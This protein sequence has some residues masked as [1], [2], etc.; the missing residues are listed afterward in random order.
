MAKKVGITTNYAI[1]YAAK[2]C[3]VDVIAAYPIT[4]QTA[5]VEKLSEFVANGELDA[6]YVPV[7]SEHS[8]LSA[9]IGA[10]VAGARAFTATSSQGLALMH[11]ILHIASGMRLPIVMSIANRSLSAPISIWAD[12]S[13]V[14]NARDAGWILFFASSAQEAYDQVILGYKICEHPDVLLPALV[15]YDGYILSHTVEP[16]VLEDDEE[17][18][19][20]VP[21]NTQRLKLDVDNPMTFGPVGPP[22]WYY[23]FKY[24][25][26]LAMEKAKEVILRAFD[27]FEKAFGR[28]YVPLEGYR[29]EDAEVVVATSGSFVGTAMY[30]VDKLREKGFKVG[31]LKVTV[32]RPFF[33][34]LAKKLLAGKKVV[35][36]IDRAISFGA[37]MGGPLAMELASAFYNEPERPL[38]ADYIM[39]I[40][41]R[42]VKPEDIEYAFKKML[43][44]A[45]TGKVEKPVEYVGV[46]V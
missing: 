31:L 37:P 1:A 41:Q 14:M 32:L 29:V 23:E 39:G 12:Q 42:D 20:F 27:E 26:V 38:I 43:E 17:V 19:R 13:D 36:A 30:V 16:V 10:S 22:D 25:Q 5:V 4:P 40:G 11:E 24:Q 7:E 9:C 3:D 35:G 15:N 44:Y 21:K 45:K 34:D 6:E 33:A 28:K 8:A 46:R 2:A 18:R